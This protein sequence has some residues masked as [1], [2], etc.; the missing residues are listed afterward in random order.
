MRS[1]QQPEGF[2]DAQGRLPLTVERANAIAAHA[3]AIADAAAEHGAHFVFE[4]P[5][6]RDASSQFAIAGREDHASLWSL[7]CMVE[8]ANRHQNLTVHF[9]QCRTGSA[10]QKTT[11]LLCSK[12][13]EPLSENPFSLLISYLAFSV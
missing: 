3:I 9:D 6:G 12:S 4:N 7:P 8:F 2:R 13:I 11:Q 10:T 1:L 5:V